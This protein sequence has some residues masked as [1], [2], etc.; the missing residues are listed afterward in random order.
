VTA[1]VNVSWQVTDQ[2]NV[3]LIGR[4]L[5]DGGHLEFFSEYLAPMTEIE[6]SVLG[7]VTWRF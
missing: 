3:M 7:K 2:M 1:D 6:P 4:N 5:L